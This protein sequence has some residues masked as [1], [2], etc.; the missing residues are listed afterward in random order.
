MRMDNF[1]LD[2]I[3]DKIIEGMDMQTDE[4]RSFFNKKT[5]E[6]VTITDEEFRAAENDEP[7]EKFPEWQ[8]EF[9]KIAQEILET[10]DY[11]A[12]PSNYDID[13]YSIMEEFCLS[14]ED[15]EL[16]DIMYSSIK[17]RGAFRRFKDNIHRYNIAEDWYNYRY[18]AL[19]QIAIEWCREN[20]I[21]K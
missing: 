6:I 14:I 7:I 3:L 11:I 13:E 21:L 10:D 17:G 18:E 8:R 12:L 19:R 16:S 4:S 2:A 20:G 1:K 9:I 15:D 5:G